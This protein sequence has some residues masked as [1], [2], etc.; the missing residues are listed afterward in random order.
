MR[1]S[2][3]LSVLLIFLSLT[4]AAFAQGNKPVVPEGM[5]VLPIGGSGQFIVPEGA[6]TRK[7]GS[8]LI[9]EG[10][11]EYMSRRFHAMAARLDNLEKTQADLKTQLDD[12]TKTVGEIKAALEKLNPQNTTPNARPQTP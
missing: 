10:T 2:R 5:E 7:V 4:C 3:I 1:K 12:L 11:K 8:Q 6:K 9:V